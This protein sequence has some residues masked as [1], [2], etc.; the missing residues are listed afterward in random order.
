MSV[1]VITHKKIDEAPAL[2]SCYQW[3]LVGDT[4]GK[5]SDFGYLSDAV[6]DNIS[7]LNKQFCELTG[8]YWIWKNTD[9]AIKGLVHY[10]RFFT[11]SLFSNKDSFLLDEADICKF[12]VNNT[13]IVPQ[14]Q[15]VLGSVREHYI[16]FHN[17]SDLACLES[18][19]QQQ[20]PDYLDAYNAVFE[21]NYFYPLNM[22][23]AKRE[24]FDSY[25]SWLFPIMLQLKGT[26][27][28]SERS[29]YQ[30]RVI[31]FISERLLSV[32]LYKNG[33]STYECPVLNTEKHHMFR[34][35]K[36]IETRSGIAITNP[37]RKPEA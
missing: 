34:L 5:A 11:K 33:F 3:L 26:I 28:T 14:R 18:V 35:R 19:I 36:A 12:L 21:G 7:Y 10:R 17:A 31:G 15:Y 4:E 16:K 1:Y 32:W 29:I 24:V 8:L 6:G 20:C 25:C 30:S 22:L 2:P 37:F 13:M 27:D 9:D 23:I